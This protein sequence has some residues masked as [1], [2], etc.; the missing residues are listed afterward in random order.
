MIRILAVS[1]S[2]AA[3]FAAT[4]PANA[5]SRQGQGPARWSAVPQPG[6]VG[7]LRP[8]VPSQGQGQQQFQGQRNF[9]SF[10]PPAPS[11]QTRS[12][13]SASFNPPRRR[14]VRPGPAR[15]PS[16]PRRPGIGTTQRSFGPQAPTGGQNFVG[17][18]A[19][20]RLR[21][22]RR[23]SASRPRRMRRLRPARSRPWRLPASRPTLRR[24]TCRRRSRRR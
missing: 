16:T 3:L 17:G 4:L 9:R 11:G 15:A 6:P 21:F 20:C 22:R 14:P 2:A 5:Q 18:P 19:A 23:R 1:I 10:N 7:L 8:A 12:A 13:R 24:V